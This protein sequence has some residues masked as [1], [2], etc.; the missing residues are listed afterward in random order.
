MRPL[1]LEFCGLGPFPF[2]N[3]ID[4]TKLSKE[5]LFLISGPTGS[6]KTTI[7]DA[8]SY[9]LFGEV[10]GSER[11]KDNLRSDFSLPEHKTYVNLSFIHRNKEYKV[12]RTPSYQRAKLRGEGTTMTKEEATLMMP[13]GTLVTGFTQVNEAIGEILGIDYSQFKQL[14]MLAQG[15][16]QKLLV[17]NSS[18]RVK[19]FRSIFQTQIYQKIQQLAKE[20]GRKVY[21]Q[22]REITTK[23]EE[24][25]NLTL[26]M[27][28]YEIAKERHDFVKMMELLSA[29]IETLSSQIE[30]ESKELKQKRKVQIEETSQFDRVKKQKEEQEQIKRELKILME[31]KVRLEDMLKKDVEKKEKL[32]AYKE[33]RD[34]KE[35]QRIRFQEIREKVVQCKAVEKEL[36][37]A[38]AEEAS[39]CMELE[40]AIYQEYTTLEQQIEA[41]KSEYRKKE[42]AW[43]KEKETWIQLQ[44]EYFAA[45]VGMLAAS[46]EVGKPCP[47]CGSVEHPK[48]AT[49]KESAVTKEDVKHQEN[50]A[51][52]AEIKYRDIY[53]KLMELTEKIKVMAKPELQQ[54][55]EEKALSMHVASKEEIQKNLLE[56]QGNIKSIEGQGKTLKEQLKDIPDFEEL[57]RQYEALVFYV[58]S[59][60]K[61]YKNNQEDYQKHQVEV[62]NCEVRIEELE[63][64][65]EKIE[66]LEMT[67][68]QLFAMEQSLRE[69]QNQ[70]TLLEEEIQ[71]LR[72]RHHAEETAQESLKEKQKE[73]AK[74][75]S[76]YG[77]VGD[78]ERILNG[79]NH[80]RLTFEQYVLIT[81]FNDILQAANGRLLKMTNGR[82]EM[83][84][85]EGVLDGRKKDNLEIQVLDYYTGKRRSIK[86]L[87]GGESFKAALCLALGLSDIVQN[88]VGGIEIDIL[89]VD[90]GFGSLD[91]ESLD[92]AVEVLMELASGNRMIG[93]ISHVSE[94]KGR[95]EQQ[96]QVEKRNNGSWVEY[97]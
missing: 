38:K 82:Y 8:I 12:E 4:F 77:I 23:M 71:Q 14:S 60:D 35:Q 68:E 10:S 76:I 30:K 74:L 89:F 78:V 13:D 15:E 37:E 40:V 69:N 54:I 56:I 20:K 79:D 6:G 86:T 85:Q 81:Y 66:H 44:S 95:I 19:I 24:A 46:L 26:G 90:E 28:D 73:K 65:R 3:I 64:Q 94:L 5:G 32:E 45:N 70:I 84:R 16:F 7:F 80:L 36:K 83:Y 55:S 11:T 25:G 57:E 97:E 61:E 87:S 34:E 47:V 42:E 53:Q 75:E 96:I 58:T 41:K 9:G 22:L 21:H 72:I 17:A 39:L 67:E 59:Y 33:E 62:S 31:Q 63:K 50:R 51:N 93:I 1:R 49:S 18:D 2:A 29:D 27:E 88:N 43:K 91:Q 92:Q 52:Q 48:V